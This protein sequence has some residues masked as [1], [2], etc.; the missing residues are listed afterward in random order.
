MRIAQVSP[1]Y[2]RVPPKFYGGTERIVSYLT[3]ELVRRGHEVTLFASGDSITKAK[4]ISCC[5]TA[6]RLDSNCEDQL[7]PHI[8][9]LELV[10]QHL[11]DFDI[12]HYHMDSIHFPLARRAH[13][14]HITTTHG[15][16]NIPEYKPLFRQFEEA[17]LV[18]I[19]NSQ[20]LPLHWANW[21]G[22]VYHGLPA[23]LFQFHE[24]EGKY[25]A[26]LG[27]ISPEKRVDRAIEIAKRV[28]IPLKIAAK[29]AKQDQ[30]YYETQVKPLMDD[31]LIDFIGEIGDGEKNDFL[32][33]ALATLFPID[34]PEPFG[35]VMIESLACGT[36]VI[37]YQNGSVPEIIESGRTGFVVNSQ[38]EAVEAVHQ[39]H[40]IDR[41]LCRETFERRFSV[42]RMTEDYVSIYEQQLN[43]INLKRSFL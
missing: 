18:S 2:E 43:V 29:V 42:Q 36:P 9:Q 22:T 28:G 14:P 35:L 17:P 4:L 16:M 1:L 31:P 8:L 26:F 6:L 3:E 20:R 34:W 27:R 39:L 25:L 5:D 15:R 7:V 33:N 11:Q 38:D 37:A 12:I 13:K 21:I 32:G 30:Q 24:K 40:K 41:K 23:N 10:Q 19:S